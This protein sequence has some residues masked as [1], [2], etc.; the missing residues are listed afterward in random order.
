MVSIVSVRR[1]MRLEEVI[2]CMRRINCSWEKVAGALVKN[3]N[4]LAS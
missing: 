2:I 4:W 1:T 3:K